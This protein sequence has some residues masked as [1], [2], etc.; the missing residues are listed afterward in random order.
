MNCERPRLGYEEATPRFPYVVFAYPPT[1]GRS[2][3]EGNWQTFRWALLMVIIRFL[4]KES[5]PRP[6][7]NSS[8]FLD[9]FLPNSSTKSSLIVP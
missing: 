3:Q 7:S 4:N 8:L 6:S 1:Q 5:S 2:G 9:F